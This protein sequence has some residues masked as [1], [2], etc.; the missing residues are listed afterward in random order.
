MKRP[1]TKQLYNALKE[2]F[3]EFEAWTSAYTGKDLE[4][5]R[6]RVRIALAKYE[7]S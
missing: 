5:L 3:D 6:R 1:N 2:L 7:G 4:A